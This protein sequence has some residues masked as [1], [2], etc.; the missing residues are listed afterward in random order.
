LGCCNLLE[1][2]CTE[3]L[4]QCARAECKAD[5][6]CA[7][8]EKC[9]DGRCRLVCEQDLDCPGDERCFAG[10]CSD[11]LGDA[12]IPRDGG[13]CGG[14]SGSCVDVDINDVRVTPYCT[15]RCE[16]FPI[17]GEKTDCPSGFVC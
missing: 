1:H 6:A 15:G 12:C 17:D 8:G 13:A 5:A 2:K 16:S 14:D 7:G 4:S 11:A 10:T 9:N 3:D